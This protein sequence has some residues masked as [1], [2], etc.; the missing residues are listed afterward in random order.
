MV[1]NNV[2]R[3]YLAGALMLVLVM[4]SR[5]ALAQVTFTKIVDNN[6]TVPCPIFQNETFNSFQQASNVGGSIVFHAFFGFANSREGI[7]ADAL[8]PDPPTTI[9]T[10]HSGCSTFAPSNIGIFS[11]N[12]S[13]VTFD[14][15]GGGGPGV[16]LVQQSIA[17]F[18]LLLSSGDTMPGWTNGF[19]N[20]LDIST[21]GTLTWHSQS[22]N[23]FSEQGV[24]TYN[25]S[26]NLLAKTGDEMPPGSGSTETFFT[27][28][29]AVSDSTGTAYS[30]NSQ[31]F[32]SGIYKLTGM[33][34]S[35][36]VDS[37]T[38]RPGGT[39]PLNGVGASLAMQNGDIAFVGTFEE[40]QSS[41]INGVYSTAGGLHTVADT[42]TP[43]PSGQGGNFEGFA[44]PDRLAIHSGTTVFVGIENVMGTGV[45]G[46]FVEY[47]GTVAKIIDIGDTLDGSV[48]SNLRFT[49]EGF[50]GQS[51]VFIANFECG[52][53][54]CLEAVYRA[55]GVGALVQPTDSDGDGVFDQNDNCPNDSNAN[56]LDFDSDG[57]GDVC[58]DDDDNDGV[59]D[60]QDLLPMGFLDVPNTNFAFSFIETLALSG[61]TGGCGGGYYCPDDPVTRAQMAVFLERG[62]NGSGFTPPAA[63]GTMFNDVAAND[64][65]A[66][67]IEQLAN[68][69]ITGGCG[70]GNYCPNDN[71]TR[72]QM[73]VFLLRAIHGSAY[74]P[75]PA[76]GVFNDVPPGSFAD[77][78][79]EQLALEMI[80]GGCGG[81]NYCP[82]DPVT[83]AQ[84]AVFLVRAFNL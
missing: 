65:A 52:P 15:L 84:M 23:G 82:D 11:F 47:A 36:V 7:F 49:R 32:N 68:D 9:V 38:P 58:D 81:G 45:S 26:P 67:F 62:I 2:L 53:M 8:P 40:P 25:G 56:Q 28:N 73:A 44:S 50:D 37:S 61:V 54:M 80:T 19:G 3:A 74:S 48:I 6:T 5:P 83:R 75:P 55:D 57:A 24:Y 35:T 10:T 41:F 31:F 1:R 79:I 43:V 39:G 72:A 64:F 22:T 69:G 12:G 16:S 71:V 14:A 78:F 76:T 18:N 4:L 63:T 30:G 70:G 34:Q 60:A 13:A 46:I 51:L 66:A 27:F 42:L 20:F 77:A 21:S 29:N 33:S 59:P 17:G